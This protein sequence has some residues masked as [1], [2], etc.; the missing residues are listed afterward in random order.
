M[1]SL[2]THSIHHSE[3]RRSKTIL[4]LMISWGPPFGFSKEKFV[5]E[6]LKYPKGG[7]YEI[8]KAKIVPDLWYLLCWRL[9]MSKVSM[10]IIR[11]IQYW[12]GWFHPGPASKP[13]LDQTLYN[14]KLFIY[15]VPGG[16]Q[17]CCWWV[18][19]CPPS[20][21][22]HQRQPHSVEIDCRATKIPILNA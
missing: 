14:K 1:D 15:L 16:K 10:P 5:N 7:P 12:E 13:F 21:S 20:L 11:K 3:Y 18:K 2:D 6:P 8:I 9:W 22:T 17:C 19:W 4:I